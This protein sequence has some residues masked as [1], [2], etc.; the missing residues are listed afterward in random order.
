MPPRLHVQL[1]SC[2]SVTAL[3]ALIVTLSASG[4]D[5]A[6]PQPNPDSQTAGKSDMKSD[7]GTKT[8]S[9]S[10]RKGKSDAQTKTDQDWQRVTD[11]QWQKLLTRPQYLVTRLKETEQP[12]SGKYARSHAAGTYLCVCCKA[13]LFNSRTKFESGTGWPSF[14]QPI[15]DRAIAQA[16]DLS[17]E[18][19]RMEVMCRRC[20]AHLGH[21]FDDGP[22]PTGLRYC[23]NSLSLDFKAASGAAS[24][25]KT[26]AKAKVKAKAKT[27]K[28]KVAPPKTP[29]K[30][31]DTPADPDR[32][33]DSGSGDAASPR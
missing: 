3:L 8:D 23:I 22:D 20:G 6:E 5:P 17:G 10:T 14:W 28:A 1:W 15:D 29:P 16:A 11:Q 13:E 2:V 7:D 9:K 26:K 18:E 19:P 4:Q 32:A 33:A 31:G 27:T 25:A 12:F 30:D 24:T 21:V